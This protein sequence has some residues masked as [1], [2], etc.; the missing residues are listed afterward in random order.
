MRTQVRDYSPLYAQGYADAMCDEVVPAISIV[1]CLERSTLGPLIAWSPVSCTS[2]KVL[3]KRF[4]S[5]YFNH[6]CVGASRHLYRTE[7]WTTISWPDGL[8]TSGVTVSPAYGVN[9]G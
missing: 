2:I 8:G 7:S 3:N 4:Y 5:L 9:C 6:I 1:A